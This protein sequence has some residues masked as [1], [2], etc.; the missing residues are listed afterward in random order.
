LNIAF[1][2]STET[3]SYILPYSGARAVDNSN[4]PLSR[5]LCNTLPAWF[6]VDFGREYWVNT[7]VFNFME[8]AGWMYSNYN[9]TD[10]KIQASND[11]INWQNIHSVKNNSQSSLVI[12]TEPVYLRFCRIYILRGLGINPQLTGIVNF[13]AHECPAPV[14]DNAYLSSLSLKDV[15]FDVPFN[16]RNTF[17]YNSTV[18]NSID[19]TIVDAVPEDSKAD[20]NVLPG[21]DVELDEG[22]NFIVVDVTAEDKVTKKDYTISVYRE[23]SVYLT[24]L[25]IKPISNVNFVK[26]EPN[27]FDKDQLTYDYYVTIPD[28]SINS[29]I[30]ITVSLPSSDCK[31]KINGSPVAASSKNVVLKMPLPMSIPVEVTLGD[32]SITYTI[33]VKM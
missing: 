2:K 7:F 13:E 8:V 19:G 23:R 1:N 22:P 3:S 31:V 30:K 16:G 29:K 18:D 14:S 24:N 10:F 26:M 15:V 12:Q 9:V 28:P 25:T 5:W 32:E 21:I 6:I 27:T 20:V 11:L 4:K 17:N 33:N